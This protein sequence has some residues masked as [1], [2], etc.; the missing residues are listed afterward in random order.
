MALEPG[1]ATIAAAALALV[2]ALAAAA[3]AWSRPRL[4]EH[5][6]LGVGA[7]ASGALRIDDSRGEGAILRAPAL[8]PGGSVTGNL[9]IENLG[10]PAS[11]V[12]SRRNLSERL[13]AGGGSLAG[14]LR[15]RIRDLTVG[16]GALVYQGTLVA[17]PALNL[18]FLP[19]GA[20]RRYRFVARLPDPGFVD[21][22]LMG[23][24]VRFDY[25][26]QL[27]RQ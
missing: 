24:R 25:R 11:L 20:Q 10:A 16:A 14:A 1:R 19:T 26:W 12:L 17:M 6:P 15:L 3:L 8:Q 2:L 9:T 13:G 18:G 7:A 23:A 4:G 27:R 22:G 5:R 21:N